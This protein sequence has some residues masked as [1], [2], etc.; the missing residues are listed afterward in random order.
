MSKK[1]YINRLAEDFRTN[2]ENKTGKI[3]GTGAHFD[4]IEVI[5]FYGGLIEYDNLYEEKYEL[6]SIIYKI[7]NND[8]YDF[9]LVIDKGTSEKLK[10]KDKNGNV[11]YGDWNLFLM[12]LLYFVINK[13]EKMENM[14]HGDIIYPDPDYVNEALLYKNLEEDNKSISTKNQNKKMVKQI[15]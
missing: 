13:N 10:T 9:K 7:D 6:R 1:N 8:N 4:M 2:F 12:K 5:N 15:I 11:S 14:K 3:I